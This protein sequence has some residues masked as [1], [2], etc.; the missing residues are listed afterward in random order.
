MIMNYKQHMKAALEYLGRAEAHTTDQ[1]F[2]AELARLHLGFAQE[3][4]HDKSAIAHQEVVELRSL[5]RK[6]NEENARLEAAKARLKTEKARLDAANARL[7]AE[8]TKLKTENARLDV[9]NA[10]LD[11]ENARLKTE[12]G[13]KS[14]CA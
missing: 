1:M 6:A 12:S 10:R 5:R 9:E 2:N 13:L 3:A 4:R 7:D 14:G 11:A 8:N